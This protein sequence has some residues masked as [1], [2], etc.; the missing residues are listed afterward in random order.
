MAYDTKFE[1]NDLSGTIS[2][3]PWRLLSKTQ[4]KMEQDF[5][6]IN[7][8]LLQNSHTHITIFIFHIFVRLQYALTKCYL[9]PPATQMLLLMNS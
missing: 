1:M 6:A 3:I 4:S 7:L 9:H 2:K 5:I 8:T